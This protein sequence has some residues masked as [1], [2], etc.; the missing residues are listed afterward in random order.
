MARRGAADPHKDG[1][2]AANEPGDAKSGTGSGDPSRSP[3]V[4]T[5]RTAQ[6]A[7]DAHRQDECAARNRCW[8]NVQAARPNESCE[9]AKRLHD[10]DKN[11][12]SRDDSA[13]PGG[14]RQGRGPKPGTTAGTAPQGTTPTVVRP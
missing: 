12:G 8:S 7:G 3:D 9:P 2:R 4:K 1:G 13:V 6:G 10:R 5:V 14:C 11:Q